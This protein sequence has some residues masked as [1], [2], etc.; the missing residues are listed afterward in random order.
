M[1]FWGIHI[2]DVHTERGVGT[3]VV[4]NV[5][6]LRMI[7]TDEWG[8]PKIVRTRRSYIYVLPLTGRLFDLLLLFEYSSQLCKL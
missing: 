3:R 8:N 2:Y 4:K 7:S 1:G 6:T 5:P